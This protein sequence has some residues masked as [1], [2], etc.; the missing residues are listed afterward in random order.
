MTVPLS[1]E[2]LYHVEGR[3]PSVVSAPR[4]GNTAVQR[5]EEPAL[6]LGLGAAG[7]GEHRGWGKQSCQGLDQAGVGVWGLHTGT[8]PSG[9]TSRHILQLLPQYRSQISQGASPSGPLTGWVLPQGHPLPSSPVCN[10][11]HPS[12][13]LFWGIWS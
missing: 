11:P 12:R 5:A 10:A 6:W 3:G 8:A 4:R 1:D 7:R 13:L 9:L 2:N